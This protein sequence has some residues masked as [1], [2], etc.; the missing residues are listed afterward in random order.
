MGSLLQELQP[1]TRWDWLRDHINQPKPSTIKPNG[2]WTWQYHHSPPPDRVIKAPDASLTPFFLLCTECNPYGAS[3]QKTFYLDCC[4]SCLTKV[5]MSHTSKL[6]IPSCT[7]P[8]MCRKHPC[9]MG[10]TSVY[11]STSE[12]SSST[13][14]DCSY[15]VKEV[16]GKPFLRAISG[17]WIQ[18]C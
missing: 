11:S 8:H 10:N 1:I 17:P 3:S 13:L 18:R 9:W 4:L 15:R 7:V 12:Y 16:L 6:G 2:W 5:K 14:F